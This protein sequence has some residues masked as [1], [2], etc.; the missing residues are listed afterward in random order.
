MEHLEDSVFNE[1]SAGVVDAIRFLESVTHMLS[2][3]DTGVRVTVKWDGA[4]AVFCGINP[5][6]DKFFVGTKS[7]FNKKPKINYTPADIDNNHSGQLADKLKTS[8]KY[9]SKLG[10]TGVLQGDLL[11]T[12]KIDTQKIDGEIYYTFQ[13]NTITYAVPVTSDLGKRIK[14]SKIGIVFHTNYKG[15]SMSDMS[16]SFNPNVASLSTTPDV[17]FDDADIK[18][19]SNVMITSS[20]SKTINSLITRC[21]SLL[22]KSSNI[23]DHISSDTKLVSEIK[24][25][26]NVLIRQ[27][28][29]QLVVDEFLEYMEQRLNDEIEKAKSERGKKIKHIAKKDFMRRVSKKKKELRAAFELHKSLSDAKIPVI[30]K[31]ETIKT[32]GTFI[33]T[34][35]G[36]KV[37]AAEGFVAINDGNKSYKLVDRLEFSRT[38]FTI[39]K[40]WD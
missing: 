16:A 32:M 34:N 12:D 37:T 18:D 30:R 28:S 14:K 17:F 1:G 38:N 9:L 36:Y 8:L 33:K 39:A 26:T 31:L 20:E 5:E 25:F 4:P 6:N 27:G 3:G 40:D 21:K 7:I 19:Y 22:R 35:N 24:T 13:P 11:Y 2:S 10:I 15:N 23:I 29:V